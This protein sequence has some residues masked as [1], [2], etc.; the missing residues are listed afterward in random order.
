M[1]TYVFRCA[2]D[3]TFEVALPMGT[4]GRASPC[5]TCGEDGGRVFAAPMLGLADPRVVAAIDRTERT[6]HEPE[7]VSAPPPA[8]GR[9]RPPVA[10]P[11]PALRRLPRP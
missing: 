8:R 3:G 1:A 5:P 9:R 10:P 4:A 7:V 11:N 6:R 2:A